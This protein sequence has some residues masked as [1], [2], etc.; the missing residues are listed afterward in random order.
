MFSLFEMEKNSNNCKLKVDLEIEWNSWTKI[1]SKCHNPTMWMCNQQNQQ[2]SHNHFSH[3]IKK[4]IDKKIPFQLQSWLKLNDC[5]YFLHMVQP[6]FCTSDIS[7]IKFRSSHLCPVCD[8]N[9]R[10]RKQPVIF[11]KMEVGCELTVAWWVF[12][13]N[14]ETNFKPG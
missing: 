6:C 3:F 12:S 14:L 11:F 4:K 1:S 13:K 2:W 10:A 8:S 5:N 7:V 9:W